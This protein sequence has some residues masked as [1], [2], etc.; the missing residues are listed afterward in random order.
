[1]STDRRR[2]S[3][4]SRRNM[5][6]ALV[7]PCQGRTAAPP[8]HLQVS[9]AKRPPL[10]SSSLVMPPHRLGTHG[11]LRAEFGIASENS[12][13]GSRRR[14]IGPELRISRPPSIDASESTPQQGTM[15]PWRTGARPCRH[16]A[17]SPRFTRVQR[18]TRLSGVPYRAA[19]FGSRCCARHP[20]QSLLRSLARAALPSSRPHLARSLWCLSPLAPSPTTPLPTTCVLQQL[21]LVFGASVILLLTACCCL[22]SIS[23]SEI[24][25]PLVG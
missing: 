3:T 22:S 2:E 4:P 1:M 14:W 13:L 5:A 11:L 12:L 10:L 19:R 24:P 16:R 6:A 20:F 8:G 21:L 18:K 7:R 15:A 17:R 25:T 23:I 9:L